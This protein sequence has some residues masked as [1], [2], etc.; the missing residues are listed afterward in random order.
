MS[1]PK[2]LLRRSP[3]LP[4]ESL[5]SLLARLARLNYY[6]PPTIIEWLCQRG[7][8]IHGRESLALPVHARMF[9][10]IA[11]L[12]QIDPAELY[13]ATPHRFAE[14][15]RAPETE[16]QSLELPSDM[17]MPRLARGIASKQI[18]PTCRAKFC[19]DCLQES[20]YHRLI[21]AHVMSAACL[22][23]KRLLANQ[24]PICHRSVNIRAVVY[25][26]CQHCRADLSVT[27]TPVAGRDDFG[28][29]GQTILQA[30]LLGKP[31][32]TTSLGIPDQPLAVLW[33][34]VEGLRFCVM[35]CSPEWGYMHR[36]MTTVLTRW[37]NELTKITPL[38]AYCLHATALKGIVNWP[39]GFYDFL[40]A[41][42][43]REARKASGSL[44]ADFGNLYGSWLERRWRHPAF[45][46]VQEAFNQFLAD[47]R[48]YA[49]SVSVMQ[50]VRYQNRPGLAEKIP[51]ISAKEAAQLLGISSNHVMQMIERGRF[52]ES[53]VREKQKRRY[54]FVRRN[55]VLETCWRWDEAMVPQEVQEQLGIGY[56]A[57][58]NMVPAGLLIAERGPDVDGSAKWLIN[59]DSVNEFASTISERAEYVSKQRQDMVTLT[60]AA[61]VL[62]PVGVNAIG[63]LEKVVGGELH[64]YLPSLPS[65]PS[66]DLSDL[67]FTKAD[68]EAYIETL[69]VKQGWVSVREIAKRIGVKSVIVSQWVKSGLLSPTVV[70]GTMHLFDKKEVD[71]FI[72]DHVFA[73]EAAKI[74]DL[75]LSTV[76][77]WVRL[78]R[79]QPVSG[80]EIDGRQRHLF[81]RQ[82]VQRLR[83]ENRLTA[84]QLAELLGISRSQILV[85]IKEGKV[86]PISGPSIDGFRHYL[87]E[88][89]PQEVLAD[90][91][92]HPFG[93]SDGKVQ[94]EAEEKG[95]VKCEQ[96][97]Q[98]MGVDSNSVLLWVESGLLSPV[99]VES[100]AHY[101]EPD[102]VDEF[103]AGHILSEEAAKILNIRKPLLRKWISKRRLACVS[104]PSI[105]GGK[106]YLFQRQE[107]ERL[108]P[109]NVLTAP[110][111][112]K[113]LGVSR[114]HITRLVKQGKLKPISGPGIDRFGHYLFERP[115]NKPQVGQS[116]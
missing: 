68:L 87:F 54:G 114:H 23:H 50:S 28:L 11:K 83:A 82:D 93:P 90:L 86:K 92:K 3:L 94:A 57:V 37:P 77:K 76:Y 4:G 70:H 66:W 55:E 56:Q 32:D 91:S 109:E 74:L 58:L 36:M 35:G 95:W 46:F 79:L 63:I 13:A 40:Q 89:P 45:Q 24:C 25:N 27:H 103:V 15:L 29:L 34:V 16:T 108:R 107:V 33:R 12:T 64:C 65:N 5:S 2:R 48:R 42:P 75:N 71:R 80:P 88:V 43:L 20:P 84:P 78:G 102:A 96:V 9:E 39:D 30:W 67:R 104:G 52:N 100:S 73:E 18:Q 113:Q 112:A 21:W 116:I 81:R 19:P 8:E 49:T 69:K 17:I 26:R 53:V 110:Q 59:R 1:E 97:A 41:Y 115:P 14:V 7:L 99:A 31:V 44:M 106:R 22:K 38:H 10:R 60:T 101:F 105:D 85:W 61:K 62:T 51:Y 6:D 47:N 72:A 98:R 111:M